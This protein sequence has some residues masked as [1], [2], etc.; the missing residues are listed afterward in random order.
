[1]NFG[2]SLEMGALNMVRVIVRVPATTANLGP[3]FDALG[4]ALDVWNQFEFETTGLGIGAPF[5]RS[6]DTEKPE[7]HVE[8]LGEGADELPR[9]AS[10]LIYKAFL[11]GLHPL[12]AP[13]SV[14]LRVHNNV[15]LSSGLGSSATAIVG[16]LAAANAL[17]EHAFSSDEL[18][19]VATEMEGHPDNVAPA[20]LG[21]LV[22]SVTEKSGRT[23]SISVTPPEELKVCVAVPDFY[24]NTRQSRG[25]LPERISRE[26]AIFSLS[27]SALWVAAVAS[28]RLDALGVATQ[29]V[30]HQPYRAALIPGLEDV[31]ESARAAGAIGVSLSGSGP[32]VAAFCRKE[33]LEPV[34]EAMRRTFRKVGVTARILHT[35]PSK[36]GV[37][38]QL[39]EPTHGELQHRLNA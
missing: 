18:I 36:Q 3:G 11:R 31:F 7:V 9:D 33:A 30:L 1:M 34:G 20:I 12:G 15:P 17:R 8:C 19:N 2:V 37:Q 27:R 32:S 4:M 14:A 10:N 22:A 13:H 5:D 24:L 29:D 38:V 6:A 23:E 26:D 35:Q 21:G 16:G 39:S 28:G 25:R